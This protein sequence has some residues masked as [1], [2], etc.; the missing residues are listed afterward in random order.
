MEQKFTVDYFIDKFSKIPEENWCT[1]MFTIG[2]AHCAYGHCGLGWDTSFTEESVALAD[3]FIKIRAT[4]INVNDAIDYNP[5]QQ[6]TP[7]QR[8][9]AALYDIKKMQEPKE[10]K[11]KEI[12]IDYTQSVPVTFEKIV[13]ELPVFSN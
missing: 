13:K 4:I 1:G 11:Q 6:P 9:L 5:Y 7:K 12:P 8:I 2:S 10:E 3:L